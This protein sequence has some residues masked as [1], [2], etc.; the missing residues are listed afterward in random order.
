M[1]DDDQ[2]QEEEEEE[3][4]SK[5]NYPT[6]DSPSFSFFLSSREKHV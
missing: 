1:D 6:Q 5:R 3:T 4:S 2:E